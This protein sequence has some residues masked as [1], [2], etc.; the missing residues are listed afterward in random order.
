M[1]DVVAVSIGRYY[2]MIIKKDGSLWAWGS[3]NEG[4]LGDGTT[5]SRSEFVWI[6]D[7]VS[8]ISAGVEHSYAIKNDGSLWAWG[9]NGKGQLGIGSADWKSHPNPTKVM[10][11][12]VAVSAS[13]STWNSSY[14]MAITADGDLWAWGANGMGQLGDGTTTDR[15]SPV[16]IMDSVMI[17]NR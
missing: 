10:D 17:P 2:I 3:N 12:V 5:E 15:Y 8:A 1:N 14:V 6:M 11:N 16:K 4:Q 13:S 9:S 7:N